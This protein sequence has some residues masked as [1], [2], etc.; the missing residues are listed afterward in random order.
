MVKGANE[1]RLPPYRQHYIKVSIRIWEFSPLFV[2]VQKRR[3]A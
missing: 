3:S 2:R 1:T